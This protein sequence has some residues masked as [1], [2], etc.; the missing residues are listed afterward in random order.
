MFLFLA[1]CLALGYAGWGI[2]GAVHLGPPAEEREQRNSQNSQLGGFF[3][4][5]LGNLLQLSEADA[6]PCDSPWC[7]VAHDA[8]KHKPHPQTSPGA[9]P[10]LEGALGSPLPTLQAEPMFPGWVLCVS[11]RSVPRL[12][13][14]KAQIFLPNVTPDLEMPVHWESQLFLGCHSLVRESET[15]FCTDEGCG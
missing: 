14:P 4:S 10:A 2:A 13:S 11:R 6:G 5:G 1:G 7:E 9:V 8:S 12:G 3:P 15:S